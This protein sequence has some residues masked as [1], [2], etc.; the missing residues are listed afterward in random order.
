MATVL[1]DESEAE[2]SRRIT[3]VHQPM[4]VERARHFVSDAPTSA[5]RRQK[6]S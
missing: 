4:D 6:S 3:A 1:H 2:S 5:L